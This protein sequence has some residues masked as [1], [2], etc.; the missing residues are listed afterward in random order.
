MKN[1]LI[2]MFIAL[3]LLPQTSSIKKCPIECTCDLD[4]TGRY[5]AIC[6]R[7]NMKI[8]P[9]KDFDEEINVIIIRKPKHTLTIGPIFQS[10]KQLEILRIIES[11][12]PTVGMHSFWGVPS[13]RLLDLSRN[14]I[15]TVSEDNF[16]GQQ[17][18][19]ELN[20]SKNKLDQIPS[21]TFKYLTDLHTL[22]LADNSLSDLE[23]KVFQMLTKLKILD[24][25]R[26]PL[27]DLQPD[28]FKDIIDLKVLKCRGCRLQN[29]NPQVYNLLNQLTDLDLGNNQFKYLD[30]DEFK[31]LKHLRRLHLDN[32]QLSVV[33]DFIFQRQRNLLYLDLSRNRLAKISGRAFNNLF[34]LTY[35]DISYN[36]LSALELDYMCHLPKLQTLNISGNVQ[37]NLLDIRPVFQNMT[38]LRSLSIADIASMPLGIFVPLSN[39]LMLNISGT[40]LNNE[41]IQILNP[42][43][44]LKELDLSRNQLTGFEEDFAIKLLNID[45]VKFEQNPFVCDVCHVGAIF[46]RIHMMK[47]QSSPECFLP[48]V[49][50]GKPINRLTQ[51]KL[52]FCYETFVD[53]G[54]DAASTSGHYSIL[55]EGRI[56]I[57]AFMA[58]AIFILV[59]LIMI[60]TIA[61]C[62]RQ[63]SNYNAAQQQT[64]D[65][66]EAIRNNEKSIEESLIANNEISY[67]IALQDRVNVFLKD[68]PS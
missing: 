14:N 28:I 37:L 65:G 6:E 26:N 51:D 25:S 16:K 57:I 33:V 4:I 40:H 24:L 60:V 45:D 55:D 13:L 38:E 56:S 20:L 61:L 17:N 19:L 66:K 47:W 58:L 39:L 34:N 29:I 22:N 27:E 11:N 46:N 59:L 48:E 31:D 44:K 43:A 50:R 9:I 3:F 63:R 10:L 8:I 41:T 32:N 1:S 12:V 49:F 62:I 30:K 21:G 2:T 42:L 35:L 52:E 64:E 5:S 53:E 18:L 68:S 15:S 67:K 7:G 23:T 54:H 36:K